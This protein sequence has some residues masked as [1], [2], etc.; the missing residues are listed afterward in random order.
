[1]SK[2]SSPIS[3]QSNLNSTTNQ[4]INDDSIIFNSLSINT[5]DMSNKIAQGIKNM[6]ISDNKWIPEVKEEIE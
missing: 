4:E 1:M 5:S 3:Y 2:S 6:I